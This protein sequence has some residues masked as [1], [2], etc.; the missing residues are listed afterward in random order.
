M[1]HVWLLWSQFFPIQ[2]TSLKPCWPS[3]IIPLPLWVSESLSAEAKTSLGRPKNLSRGCFICPPAN[4]PS[5][6][7][8]LSSI[9]HANFIP[10]WQYTA[11][12]RSL[13]RQSK[14]CWKQFSFLW[15][16]LISFQSFFLQLW[17]KNCVTKIVAKKLC[18]KNCGQTKLWQQKRL[19]KN[20][21]ALFLTV[22]N[23]ITTNCYIHSATKTFHCCTFWNVLSHNRFTSKYI[24][25][26]QSIPM[27]LHSVVSRL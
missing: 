15:Q 8:L 26:T 19:W 21:P 17:Q 13:K 11:H 16:Q 18:N 20:C 9:H 1:R 25:F 12:L 6:L 10:K 27:F 14:D 2:Q 3:W 23:T 24:V 22:H 7:L 4:S 5:L